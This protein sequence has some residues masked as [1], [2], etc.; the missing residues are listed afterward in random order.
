MATV[1]SQYTRCD[2]YHTILLYYYTETKG[3]I[4][5]S[6]NLKGLGTT[7]RIMWTGLK[8]LKESLLEISVSLPE[9]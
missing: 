5:G 4:Y 7:N 3:M 2:L 9:M 6:V 8:Q 1:E